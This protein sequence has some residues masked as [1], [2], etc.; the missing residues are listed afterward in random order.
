MPQ[1]QVLFYRE[2]DGAVPI[3][4]WLNGLGDRARA[5]CLVRIERLKEVGHQLRRPEADYLLSS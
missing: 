3:L 5:K 2:D 1:T 4:N